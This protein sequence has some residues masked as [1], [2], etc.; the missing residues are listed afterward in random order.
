MKYW[1]YKVDYSRVNEFGQAGSD[2][3]KQTVSSS[4]AAS[5]SQESN[6]KSLTEKKNQ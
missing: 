3:K 5:S 2:D 6:Q 4:S 1:I